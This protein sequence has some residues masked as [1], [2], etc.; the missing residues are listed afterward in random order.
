MLDK[1]TE[2]LLQRINSLCADGNYKVLDKDDLLTAFPPYLAQSK[3][4]LNSI[5]SYL[6][7]HEYVSVKYADAERGIYCLYPLPAG[8]LYSERLSERKAEAALN[9]K[10]VLFATFFGA[11]AGALLGAGMVAVISAI[12]G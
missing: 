9:F 7:E 10:K 5:L 3:E 1:R 6:R 4:G 11:F 2:C 8:R 12:F